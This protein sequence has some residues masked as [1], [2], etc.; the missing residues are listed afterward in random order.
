MKSSL[1]GITILTKNVQDYSKLQLSNNDI[2]SL[3]KTFNGCFPKAINAIKND[4]EGITNS[5]IKFIALYFMNLN[6]TEIAVLL[7]LTYG[8]AN[9][10]SN[11]IKNILNTKENLSQFLL[12]FIKLNF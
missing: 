11:K 6:D 12:T 1:D 8:A 9:K 5:D 4:F 2:I 7:G 10:R 3:T